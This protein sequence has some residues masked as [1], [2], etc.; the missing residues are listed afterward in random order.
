MSHFAG[1]YTF[2]VKI[3]CLSLLLMMVNVVFGVLMLVGEKK[4]Q[5]EDL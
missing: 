3:H 2:S 4:K 1:S 5:F